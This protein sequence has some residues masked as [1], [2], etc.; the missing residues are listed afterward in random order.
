MLKYTS[1]P[2][3]CSSVDEICLMNRSWIPLCGNLPWENAMI[4]STCTVGHSV[5]Q[6]AWDQYYHPSTIQV[7]TYFYPAGGGEWDTL[8]PESFMKK[9]VLTCTAVHWK[10]LNC[11]TWNFGCVDFSWYIGGKF[12]WIPSMY[13]WYYVVIYTGVY[14]MSIIFFITHWLYN[15]TISN[16]ICLVF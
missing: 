11:K 1:L 13:V 6:T 4:S 14:S 9:A 5:L 7:I 3:T 8:V 15:L 10:K 12:S 16:L 2:C